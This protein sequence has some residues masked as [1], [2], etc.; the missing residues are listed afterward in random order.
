MRLSFL[1]GTEGVTGS[2]FKLTISNLSLLID[3]GMMQEKTAKEQDLPVKE[4]VDYC[5]SPMPTL[6]IAGFCPCL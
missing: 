4:A 6:T 5:Y 2:C 1:G 3:C